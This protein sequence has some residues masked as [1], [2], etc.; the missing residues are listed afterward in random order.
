MTPIKFR[1]VHSEVQ[2][3]T[4]GGG[5]TAVCLCDDASW[6]AYIAIALNFASGSNPDL[7]VFD[8]LIDV[9]ES[10]R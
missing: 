10:E 6:A 8:D 9:R 2:R 7:P 1:H 3:Q 5:W 4:A